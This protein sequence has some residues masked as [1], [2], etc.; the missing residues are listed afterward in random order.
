MARK[1]VIIEHLKMM[2]YIIGEDTGGLDVDVVTVGLKTKSGQF[3]MY[4]ITVD[5]L[6]NQDFMIEHIV[7][8]I[9]E[10]IING[11]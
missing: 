5:Q 4:T 3:F 10:A 6:V 1:A 2:G 9:N 7:G 11:F 8:K